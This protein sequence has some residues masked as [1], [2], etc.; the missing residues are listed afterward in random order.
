[1]RRYTGAHARA[2]P[3][4]LIRLA[5][6]SVA[7]TAVV[8]VQD[9]LGLGSEGRMNTPAVASGNWTWRFETGQLTAELAADLRTLAEVSGRLPNGRSLQAE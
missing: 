8:P 3:W 1:M 6:T 9:V 5:Y 7:E 2:V 4:G